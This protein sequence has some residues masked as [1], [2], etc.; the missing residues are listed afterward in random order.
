ML[1][2]DFSKTVCI[3]CDTLVWQSSPMPGVE[4]K[5]LAREDAERG[6][7]TS[8]VRYAEGSVFRA[9]PHPLGEEILVLEGTF[10]DE[11]GAYPKGTYFR[12]PPGSSHAPY[13]PDGCVLFVKL[14]QFQELDSQHVVCEAER[15][16]NLQSGQV[17]QLHQYQSETV[18]LIRVAHQVEL[19]KSFSNGTATEIL[20]V[21]G[22]IAFDAV[23]YDALSWLRI[24]NIDWET[25]ELLG[26]SVLWVKQGH[27]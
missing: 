27:F 26:E 12:N 24:P 2:M 15:F 4:R 9:H 19:I 20:V 13:S 11:A 1:N 10:C 14:H 17:M 18:S 22:G 16:H 8:I 3:H 25:I 6:H 7:A 23:T 5:L 21:Q